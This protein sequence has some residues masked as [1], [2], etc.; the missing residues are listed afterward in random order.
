MTNTL[1]LS[2]PPVHF[3]MRELSILEGL[4]RVRDELT[5]L[6]QDRST[7]IKTLDII[8][9]YERTVEQVQLLNDARIKNPKEQNQG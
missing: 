7:Y 2:Y 9:L 6:K 1:T 3:D 5:L 8:F 4:Q